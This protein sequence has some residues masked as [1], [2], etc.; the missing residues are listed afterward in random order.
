MNPALYLKVAPAEA[1][2]ADELQRIYEESFPRAERRPWADFKFGAEVDRAKPGPRVM[3]I[4]I[5]PDRQ[6]WQTIGMF[7]HWEFP[8]ILYVEHFAIDAPCRG[9]GIG[10][11]VFQAMGVHYAQQKGLVCVLEVEPATPDDPTTMRRV[12]FYRR[13]G[14]E[15]VDTAYVQP[16]YEPGQPPVEMW[17]MSS[18]HTLDPAEITQVLYKEVYKF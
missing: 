3:A 12:E 4:S 16:P 10:N 14:L 1:D 2:Q 11:G 17:L 7:S 15:V 9:N 18:D 13:H 6:D 5:S 8:G